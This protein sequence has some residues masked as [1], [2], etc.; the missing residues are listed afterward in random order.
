VNPPGCCREPSGMLSPALRDVVVKAYSVSVG[1][2]GERSDTRHATPE[3]Q[4]KP[5]AKAAHPA[6]CQPLDRRCARGA[7]QVARAALSPATLPQRPSQ[8][9]EKTRKALRGALAPHRGISASGQGNPPE[10]PRRGSRRLLRGS[11]GPPLFD[12]LASSPRRHRCP[13]PP[14]RCSTDPLSGLRDGLGFP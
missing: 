11:V 9:A 1:C 12:P 10:N 7:A 4:P 5:A 8:Q 2:R 14:D 6:A 13:C 3:T